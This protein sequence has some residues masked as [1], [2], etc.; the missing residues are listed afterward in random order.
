M[1]AR[2]ASRIR[3]VRAA[4]TAVDCRVRKEADVYVGIDLHK[5]FLQVAAIDKSGKILLEEKVANDR[6]KIRR[7]L[8]RFPKRTRYVLEASSVSQGVTEF[9]LDDLGLDLVVSGPFHNKVIAM[10][11]KKTDKVDARVLAAMLRD[12]AIISSYVPD[13]QTAEDRELVR[14]RQS[15]SRSRTT[16]KIK[17]RSI[18]LQAG[19]KVKGHAWSEEFVDNLRRLKDYRIDNY[20]DMIRTLDGMAGVLDIRIAARASEIDDAMRLKKIPGG[21]Y[22]WALVFVSEIGDITRFRHPGQLV[23]FAGLAPSVRGSA[24]KVRGGGGITKR[25]DSLLRHAAVQV[26]MTHIRVARDTAFTRFY[27]RLAEGRG[28]PKARVATG[29]KILRAVFRMLADGREYAPH[30]GQNPRPRLNS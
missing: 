19:T 2:T 5:A 7:F 29:A 6:N 12:D 3:V 13:R 27:E 18:L 4:G 15:V 25:G 16:Y 22:F 23:S 26:A 8:A 1:R 24:G 20:L 9:M 14:H 28:M 30:H 17:I 21:G 11:K 10:S